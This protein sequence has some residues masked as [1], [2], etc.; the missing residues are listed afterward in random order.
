[1]RLLRRKRFDFLCK[2]NKRIYLQLRVFADFI[3]SND[4]G[5]G[6]GSFILYILLAINDPMNNQA[7]LVGERTWF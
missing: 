3:V 6:M 1:M 4:K 7:Y 5:R 2:Y